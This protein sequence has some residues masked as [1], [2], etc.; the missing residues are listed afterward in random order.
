MRASL[1]VS[2][3]V[4]TNMQT[5]MQSGLVVLMGALLLAA[6]AAAAGTGAAQVVQT[7]RNYP[8]PSPCNTTLQACISASAD[9]DSVVITAST[10]ITSV[11]ITRAVNLIGSV[12]GGVTTT[13]SA[14]VGQHAITITNGITRPFILANLIIKR[15]SAATPS[16]VQIDGSVVAPPLFSAVIISNFVGGN[17][18]GISS[19]GP[20]TL[21]L[22]NAQILGNSATVEGGG[23]WSAGSVVI[24]SSTLMSNSAG[25]SGGA[26]H[27]Q[28]GVVLS[29]TDFTGNTSGGDGG[30][31]YST[32]VISDTG[33][34][35]FLNKSVAGGGALRSSTAWLNNVY[36]TANHAALDGGA[37]YADVAVADTGGSYVSN[38]ADKNGGAIASGGTVVMTGTNFTVNLASSGGA[39][40]ATGSVTATRGVFQLN[41]A[42]T[43]TG[44]SSAGALLGA[45]VWVSGTFFL[46]NSANGIG[47]AIVATDAATVINATISGNAALPPVGGSSLGGGIS[48]NNSLVMIDTLVSHNTADLGCGVEMDGPLAPLSI[49][50][51]T[52][53]QNGSSTCSLGGAIYQRYG[54]ITISGTT[55]S[56]NRASAGG[57]AISTVGPISLTGASFFSN[58]ASANTSTGGALADYGQGASIA[59]TLFISNTAGQGGAVAIVNTQAADTS[60]VNS[61]F[62]RNNATAGGADVDAS[63]I[64]SLTMLHNTFADVGRVN[65]LPAI[66]LTTTLANKPVVTITNNIFTSHTVAISRSLAVTGSL[67]AHNLLFGVATP[68]VGGSALSYTYNKY[69]DPVFVNPAANDFHL[70]PGTAAADAGAAVGVLVDIDGQ[71]RPGVYAFG[72]PDIG[73]D[74]SAFVLPVVSIQVFRDLN[75]D[76]LLGPGEPA[77]PGAG[78]TLTSF[79]AWPYGFP[80][81]GYTGIQSGYSDVGG[82]LNLSM[83][84]GVVSHTLRLVAP[85]YVATT[86]S[87]FTFTT[88][89]GNPVPL[90][91]VGFAPALDRRVRLPLVVK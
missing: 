82:H 51:G 2:G 16:G 85:G 81:N 58:T 13:L 67:P 84:T 72:Y 65:P 78:I 6:A 39:V 1:A 5:R 91:Q 49:T 46:Q 55:F 27:A 23:I 31:V 35:Y 42:Y 59:R 52:F 33:G 50:G 73:Y 83:S 8:G 70:G 26:I 44:A 86:A 57:G 22:I 61:L 88:V 68:S 15:T 7:S 54:P 90:F 29:A 48:V 76:G 20:G 14:P 62:A 34:N 43:Y 9:G 41:Q 64:G 18:G 47:G 4:F 37:V 63:L 60:I 3:V 89:T 80:G 53:D 45:G 32:G 17:G 87:V 30:A 66:N 40:F 24:T 79:I 28:G 11:T 69:G 74:E 77:L 36:L 38:T 56:A 21:R 12:V 25:Q 19:F 10:Y 75:R 71:T